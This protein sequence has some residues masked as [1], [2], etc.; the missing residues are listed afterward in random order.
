[1]TSERKTGCVN[2]IHPSLGLSAQHKDK[3]Q[4]TNQPTCC[5]SRSMSPAF[6]TMGPLTAYSTAFTCGFKVS[7][8]R[9]FS[10]SLPGWAVCATAAS[11]VLK[12]FTPQRS[13][14]PGIT[15]RARRRSEGYKHSARRGRCGGRGISL[16]TRYMFPQPRPHVSITESRK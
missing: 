16:P 9:V 3:P 1:M 8:V 13:G 15:Q 2:Y 10:R 7:M 12:S 4:R 14:G 11:T 5:S 6:R